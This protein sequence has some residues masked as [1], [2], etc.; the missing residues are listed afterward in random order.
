MTNPLPADVLE[1][2]A[3][4][5]RERLHNSVI[6]LRSSMKERLDVESAARRHLVPA[7]GVASLL[8][9]VAG[10]TTALFLDVG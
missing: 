8:G 1:Q 3:A 2:R 4:V 5:E 9:I 7:I 10:W 6:Q